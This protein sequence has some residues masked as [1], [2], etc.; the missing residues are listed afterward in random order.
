MEELMPNIEIRR[1]E[2]AERIDAWMPLGAYAFESTPPISD[3]QEWE[4]FAQS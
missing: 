3:R 1:V 4:R 2:G